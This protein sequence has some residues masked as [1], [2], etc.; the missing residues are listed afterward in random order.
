M[1]N[2]ERSLSVLKHNDLIQKTRYELTVEEQKILLY[3]ISKIKPTDNKLTEYNIPILDILKLLNINDGGKNY[4]YIKHT[5]KK[6]SDKSF[7]L[8]VDNKEYLVRW[9]EHIVI[10]KDTATINVRIHEQLAPYLLQ[11]KSRFTEYQ[12]YNILAMRGK[13]S[14]RLYEILKSYAYLHEVDLSIND[15][16][17]KIGIENKYQDFRTVKQ[18]VLEPAKAEINDF[19]DLNIEYKAIRKSNR[20]TAIH[21]DIRLV[22]TEQLILPLSE[23]VNTILDERKE[24]RK[25]KW[26]KDI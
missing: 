1:Y 7:W 16:R 23:Y 19:T 21:F 26:N 15:F 4:Q 14:I 20:V 13:Y 17:K 6:L 5:I 2:E 11:V 22:E 3:V 25:K 18:F 24:E 10:D 9:L 12:I 8:F